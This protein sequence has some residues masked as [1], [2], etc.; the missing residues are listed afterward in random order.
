MRKSLLKQLLMPTVSAVTPFKSW[1][2]M[3]AMC[4]SEFE[5][6][7]RQRMHRM[8]L[9]RELLVHAY[10]EVDL[11]RMKLDKAGV[12]PVEVSYPRSFARVPITSKFDLRTG[13]PDRQLARSYRGRALR[14]SNT[15]G[16]TGRPLLLIQDIRDISYK[17]AS[18]LRSR[19][20]AGVD[21]L[22]VQT[23]ITP[24]E[25]QPCLPEGE[26]LDF[27]S[28]LVRSG[29]SGGRRAALF[30]FLERQVVNPLIHRRV[31]LEP[32]WEG[33]E[34]TGPVDFDSYLKRLRDLQPEVLSLYPLYA[35]LLSKY[36]R[37]QGVAPPKVG[38][39]IDFSGG[40]VTPTMRR[41][42]EETWGVRTAQSCGGCEFARYAS[43]CPEDP[44]RMH[45]AE[46]YCYVEAVR[47][48][49]QLCAVGELGNAIVTSLHGWAM[50]IIRL[51]PGDVIRL[52]E[53]PCDCGRRSRRLEHHGRIQALTRNAEGRWVTAREIW[54]R[55]LLLPGVEMFQLVQRNEQRYLLRI[56]GAPDRKLNGSQLQHALEELLGSAAQVEIEHVESIRPERSGK[57]Q[58]VKSNTFREFRTESARDREVPVN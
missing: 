4:N 33:P 44:D 34:P 58:L 3:R 40:V 26:S 45:I 12:D 47:S 6:L 19:Q 14:Y 57:L 37:R 30:V 54:D 39:V 42:V 48:D 15:S 29:A 18:I 49:G 46:S 53:D 38:G 9:I 8:A 25:C 2:Y 36:I 17:Y 24:N 52:I 50:P 32:F 16:T 56:V 28:P 31:M 20:V 21:P 55:L 13:F 23:R 51:E 1:S 10:R 11:Y 27:V 5:P 41:F 7:Q 22:A 35:V 43:S